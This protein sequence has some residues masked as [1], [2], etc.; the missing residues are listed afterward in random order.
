MVAKGFLKLPNLHMLIKQKISS[1]P[2]NLA[3]GNSD[4]L[5][6]VLSTKINLL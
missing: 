2:K 6:K 1:L 4:E 3:L 5:L